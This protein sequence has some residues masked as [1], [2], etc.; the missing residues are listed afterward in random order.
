MDSTQY[1]YFQFEIM[2][3]PNLCKK[4]LQRHRNIQCQPFFSFSFCLEI[5]SI[6]LLLKI[7]FSPRGVQ[8]QYCSLLWPRRPPH[9]Q[10][11]K[12]RG[13]ARRKRSQ[14]HRRLQFYWWRCTSWFV[15]HD[16]IFFT[17]FFLLF[18]EKNF[19]NYHI[20]ISNSFV[21]MIL[22]VFFTNLEFQFF[23]FLFQLFSFIFFAR[24]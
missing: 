1:F 13:S 10:R 5:C 20:N 21:L 7:F 2:S 18:L 17:F 22:L 24:L 16:L 15:E 9:W 4:K 6:F 3:S 8:S 11:A 19:E 14:Q 12:S 23:L